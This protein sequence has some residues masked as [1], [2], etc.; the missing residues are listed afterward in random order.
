ME[1]ARLHH[2]VVTIK[3]G[4]VERSCGNR[5]RAICMMSTNEHD[6]RANEEH[7]N[8]RVNIGTDGVLREVWNYVGPTG[9]FVGNL[10]RLRRLCDEGSWFLIE[11]KEKN[12][13]DMIDEGHWAEEAQ[14][15][16]E[17]IRE[18]LR[19]AI[20]SIV[21]GLGTN[22]GASLSPRNPPPRPPSSPPKCSFLWGFQGLCS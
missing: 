5:K 10:G 11:E 3:T 4:K 16:D 18:T 17:R 13:E 14:T 12:G 1:K 19:R 20:C 15:V 21:W 2:I 6:T 9:L 8:E 7:C 22:N